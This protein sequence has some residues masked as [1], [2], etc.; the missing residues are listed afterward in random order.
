MQ[1]KIYVPKMIEIPSEYLAGLAQR[2]HGALG[3]NGDEVSATRGHL[4]RQAVMD[5]LLRELDPLMNDDGTVDTFV[6]PQ[7][8]IPLEIDNH[9][10]TLKELLATLQ[11][12]KSGNVEKQSDKLS[13][14]QGGNEATIPIRRAA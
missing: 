9:T 13:Q 7:G 3:G 2:A 5:G 1:V 8:E 6:D 14:F 11:G 12:Q 10:V 4:V